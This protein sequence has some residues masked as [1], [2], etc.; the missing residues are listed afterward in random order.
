MNGNNTYKER[1]TVINTGEILFEDYCSSKGH[2][3]Y[4]IGFSE[5]TGEIDKYYVINPYIRNIPD[6]F[7]ETSKGCFMVNVKGSGNFK[8]QEI[9]MLPF[10]V[11][12]YS[13]KECPLIYAFC[14]EHKPIYILKPN[15]VMEKYYRAEDKLWASDGKVYRNLSLE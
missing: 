6:Y 10:F 14:I 11:K 7:V 3:F 5:K 2:K 12:N 9:E 4:K 15:Q 1:Q 8:Q 13:T